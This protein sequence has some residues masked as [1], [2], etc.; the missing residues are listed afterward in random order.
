VRTILLVLSLL[1][2]YPLLSL[3]YLDHT[4]VFAQGS[5]V[6]MKVVNVDELPD[7]L[8]DV[9]SV[10]GDRCMITLLQDRA[11]NVNVT[12][13]TQVANVGNVAIVTDPMAEWYVDWHQWNFFNESYDYIVVGNIKNP[14]SVDGIVESWLQSAHGGMVYAISELSFFVLPMLALFVLWRLG[15]FKIWKLLFVVSLYSVGV[16]ELN[17]LSSAHDVYVQTVQKAFGSSFIALI[18]LTLYVAWKESK[19]DVVA[20]IKSLYRSA[21]SSIAEVME[22]GDGNT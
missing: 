21:I 7:G 16:M 2:L 11:T 3:P 5:V 15:G 4:T 14:T 19:T 13:I 10:F 9:A 8:R 12:A 6:R 18:P 22:G 20:K 1:I 17:Y